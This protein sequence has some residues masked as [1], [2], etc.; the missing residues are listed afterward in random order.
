MRA[1]LLAAACALPFPVAA[2]QMDHSGHDMSQQGEQDTP[3]DPHAGHDMSAMQESDAHKPDPHA[4][5]DMMGMENG[6]MALPTSNPPAE[7]FSGPEHAADAL[8][9]AAE[10]AAARE[11]LRKE[12]GGAVNSLFNVD[13]LELQSGEGPDAYAWEANA[14]IG[15]DIDKLWIKTEGEGEVKG[16][17]DDAEVQA[18]W[19]RA[20]GPWFDFQAGVRYDYRPSEPD[21]SHIVLGMQGLAPYLFEID[22]AG[23]LSD[24]GDLTARVEAEYDLR[25]TQQL[26]LQPR[27]ELNFAAQDI[28]ELGIGAGLSSVDAGLRLRYEIVPEFAPYIGVE[29]QTDLGETR[30]FTRADG[31]DPDRSV[32]L[33]GVKFWF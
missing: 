16:S 31:G 8:F 23:F 14:W 32:F 28:P 13:R 5:H 11:Q 17:L 24:E 18:L 9:S 26:I 12:Q 21:T 30:D 27:A 3:A 25:I 6:D 22:V 10:M 2:Q 1:A 29:Y 33:A 20:I 15:G 19:S 7:A 4:G